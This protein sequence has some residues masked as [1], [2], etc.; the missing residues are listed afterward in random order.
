VL[1]PD[2]VYVVA[3]ETNQWDIGAD[4]ALAFVHGVDKK[5]IF[6]STKKVVAADD[7]GQA[8]GRISSLKARFPKC[9]A[10]QI[11]AKGT[12]DYQTGEG[13]RVAPAMRLLKTLI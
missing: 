13:M 1:F 8:S 5:F 7:D 9:D 4:A 12:K 2:G 3:V 10:W 11:H 6:D